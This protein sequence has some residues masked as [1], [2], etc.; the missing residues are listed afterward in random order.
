MIR[1]EN[2]HKTF[3]IREDKK[4][5]VLKGISLRFDRTGFNTI[6][7]RSGSGKTT[8]LNI[9]GGMDRPDSGE[10]YF[11]GRAIRGFEEFRS[12]HTGYVFQDY[13]LVKHLSAMDN[14][15]LA[16]SSPENLANKEKRAADILK[17]VGLE[18]CINK[19]PSQ[20]SGGQRQRVSIARMLAKDA[21]IIICD[22]ATS[23][24]D[25]ES[26]AD[27]YQLLKK[28][29]KTRCIIYV[30]HSQA[31]A[32]KYSDRI[33][34]IDSGLISADSRPPKISGAES[35]PKENSPKE[36]KAQSGYRSFARHLARK[37]IAGRMGS[38]IKYTVLV[39]IVLFAFMASV[40]I[41]S[42]VFR[43]YIHKI[44]LNR[45]VGISVFDVK[46]AA[47]QKK[48]IEAA[49]RGRKCRGRHRP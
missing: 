40:F 15:L 37:N 1:I 23:S 31:D 25:E 35:S 28:L 20:M 29:S 39:S 4:Q 18:D 32:E 7:G 33:I 13:N 12:D 14:V 34:R 10:I 41:G 22:E 5:H 42:D 26:S 6:L 11:E 38:T 46:D 44:H 17:S 2:I 3:I 47:A 43:N 8:L 36:G 45:G 21:K 49:S 9:I 24:L 19:K 27:V 30:T 48:L 16:I